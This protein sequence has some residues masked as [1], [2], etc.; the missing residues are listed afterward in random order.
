MGKWGDRLEAGG[1]KDGVEVAELG[2]RR[3][4]GV[5]ILIF[6]L[7]F[8]PDIEKGKWAW[9]VFIYWVSDKKGPVGLSY[10]KDHL[11]NFLDFEGLVLTTFQSVNSIRTMVVFFPF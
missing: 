2:G 8:G 5:C 6:G 3:G 7:G 4:R 1:G 11:C 9:G 10:H